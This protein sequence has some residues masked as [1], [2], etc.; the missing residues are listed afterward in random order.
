MK[1]NIVQFSLVI[2]GMIMTYTTTIAQNQI[3]AVGN[4][5][6]Y[7]DPIFGPVS[8]NLP[9]PPNGNQDPVYAD[10]NGQQAEYASNAYHH[11]ITGQLLFFIIDGVIYDRDG[12][13]ISVMYNGA[14]NYVYGVT[15]VSI[16]PDPSNCMR[17]YIFG[18][19][20]ANNFC[21]NDNNE[22]IVSELYYGVLDLSIPRDNPYVENSDRYGDLILMPNDEYVYPAKELIPSVLHTMF[23]GIGATQLA[24]TP[25]DALNAHYI[26]YQSASQYLF[27]FKLDDAGLS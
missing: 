11:P 6:M 25:R 2:I 12:Y 17:Y 20:V 5:S 21:E 26:F 22:D 10:Y 16:V 8:N 18:L 4:Q 15:E 1:T 7:Y 14:S 24:V 13:R 27:A 19:M 23:Q 9:I 3:W